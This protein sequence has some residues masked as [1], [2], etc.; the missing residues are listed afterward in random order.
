MNSYGA[1]MATIQSGCTGNTSAA[2][3]AD[4]VNGFYLNELKIVNGFATGASSSTAIGVL[5]E[6]QSSSS[7]TQTVVVENS[8]I[9]G[10][11]PPSG[12]NN[13]GGDIVIIGFAITGNNGPLNDI[14][15]LNAQDGQDHASAC[16][17]KHD[18]K[19]ICLSTGKGR[20]AARVPA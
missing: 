17:L 15:I 9:T 16:G 13:T 5:L 12:S 18:G 8:E 10:F 4:N 3:I 14:Q 11:A 19:R 6:N 7:P 20:V 1:G 2:V